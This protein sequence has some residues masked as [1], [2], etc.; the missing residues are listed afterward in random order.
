MGRVLAAASHEP[1]H[2]RARAAAEQVA[3]RLGVGL[4]GLVNLFN[5]DRIVLGG[6]HAALL[7]AVPGRVERVVRERSFLGAASTVPIVAARLAGD[8]GLVGA[9]EL[10]LQPLLDRPRRWTPAS[11]A[12]RGFAAGH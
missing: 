8:A 9:A 12:G 1:P 7:T 3:D 11:P 2:P 6:L 10:A 4:A 5:P